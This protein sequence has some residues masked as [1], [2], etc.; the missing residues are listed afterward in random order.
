VHEAL[1][2]HWKPFFDF[3]V[4]SGLRPGE[5]IA[6]KPQDID[7]DT[8]FL[9]V[10]RAM[11]TDIDG[12]PME[13]ETKNECSDREFALT[14][15]MLVALEAQKAIHDR[16]GCEYFFCTPSGTQ[17]DLS[18]FREDV[19]IPALKKA[20]VKVRAFKQ[21]RHT[22]ATLAIASSEDLLWIASIMGHANTQMI[23]RHYAKFVKN[24][25]GVVNGTRMTA[26]FEAANGNS[27]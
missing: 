13:G 21:A 7:W 15:P 27:G 12:H 25:T 17:V 22:F 18:N 9:K 1:P 19:W 3:A 24:A 8:K 2:E 10:E 5:L 4:S 11:T 20:G 16:L 26:V 14:P 6:L 23:H